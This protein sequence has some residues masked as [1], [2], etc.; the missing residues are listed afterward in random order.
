[1]K[2]ILSKLD[3]LFFPIVCV[4]IFLYSMMFQG[5]PHALIIVIMTILGVY[6]Y[7]KDKNIYRDA[8]VVVLFLATYA[9]G[10]IDLHGGAAKELQYIILWIASYVLGKYSMQNVEKSNKNLH[11][12]LALMSVGLFIQGLLNYSNYKDGTVITE[13]LWGWNEF[14]TGIFVS[15]TV[16]A[17][18]FVLAVAA[19]FIPVMFFKRN[20]KMSIV[21]LVLNAIAL[22]LDLFFARGRLIVVMQLCMLIIMA[23]I[24][25]AKKIKT[26]SKKNKRK[27]LYSLLIIVAAYILFIVARKFNIAGVG[28]LYYGS[29]L[30]REGGIL[31][32]V[33]FQSIKE[34][35]ILVFTNPVGG[36]Q[37]PSLG[38]PHNVFLLFGQEYD[39]IVFLLLMAYVVISI[40]YVVDL[41][42]NNIVMEDYLLISS[43][44]A[45][46]LYYL[47]ETN[48]WRNRYYWLFFLLIGGMIKGRVNYY[49]ELGENK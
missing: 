19:L 24:I 29:F 44:V 47:I 46:N 40:K 26:M 13:S 33:R 15:R 22:Y 7:L 43:F 2:A 4:W 17:F 35:M 39:V 42:K 37:T 9:I 14:W 3:S 25:S 45:V 20:I 38:I 21:I 36:W 12:I 5:M 28:D 18:D 10:M 6:I 41:F 48:P 49:K 30:A 8:A 27:V 23:L 31:N 34:G 16:Y 1:M 11:M 32:N